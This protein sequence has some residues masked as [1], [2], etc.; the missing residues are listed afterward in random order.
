MP[1]SNNLLGLEMLSTEILTGVTYGKLHITKN[2]DL[3]QH[4]YNRLSMIVVNTAGWPMSLKEI[5]RN[6]ENNW[7]S[8]LIKQVLASVLSFS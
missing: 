8:S 3:F 6:K 1:L 2:N 4:E 7:F 5:Y